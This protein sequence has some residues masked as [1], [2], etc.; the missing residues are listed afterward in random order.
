MMWGEVSR[1]KK[2]LCC[3]LFPLLLASAALAAG[4]GPASKVKVT[5]FRG[6]VRSAPSS[7]ADVI[8]TAERDR[9]FDV[10]KKVGE[11]YLVALPDNKQG[12]LSAMIVVEIGE[13]GKPVPAPVPAVA[14]TASQRPADQPVPPASAQAAGPFSKM[15]L[16]LFGGYASTF[17]MGPANYYAEWYAD[18]LTDVQESTDISVP[19]KG[20]LFY[21]GSFTYF[22]SPNFGVQVAGGYL[23]PSV[24]TT[25]DFTFSGT[26]DST[27][28]GASFN[29]SA[30][31]TG[32][33]SLS[34][35]VISLDA[36]GRFGE[37]SLAYSLFGGL[38]LFRCS[39]QASGTVGYGV[40]WEQQAGDAVYQNVDAL[41][42]PAE[43]PMTSWTGIGF[44]LG[45]GFSYQLSSG[46][47]LS[48]EARYFDGGLKNLSW[49]FTPGSYDGLFTGTIKQWAATADDASFIAAYTTTLPVNPS[50]FQITG[51]IKILF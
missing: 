5:V 28:G 36:V 20:G 6:N 38:T 4:P 26:W 13:D 30:S 14:P 3:A 12:Y 2:A 15:E 48:L 29:Q 11:W 34:A 46:L 42:I 7:D 8:V 35:T 24:A 49:T 23:S 41:P 21:G 37:G 33:S 31:W 25:S 51:G 45:L 22:F 27:A 47:A 1:M 43:I 10:I 32:K 16:S 18:H 19:A 50:F 39:F 44:N 9:V 40:T 17:K